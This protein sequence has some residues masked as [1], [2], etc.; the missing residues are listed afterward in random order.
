MCISKEL[1]SSFICENVA[2]EIAQR[3]SFIAMHPL[4]RG[5]PT[6]YKNL[7]TENFQYRKLKFGEHMVRQGDPLKAVCFVIEG[8]VKLTVNPIEH[9]ESFSSLLANSKKK[10]IQDENDGDENKDGDDDDDSFVDP[11]KKI[12]V[13]QRRKLKKTDSFYASELRYRD[14]D[15]CTLGSQAVVGDIESILDLNK[16]I[17]TA[18]CIQETSFYEMDLSSFLRFI[19]KKN[20]E[21]Y[22]KMRKLV[23]EKLLHRNS[24]FE[25]TIPIYRALLTFFD[26][27]KPK[28]NRKQIIKSYNSKKVNQKQPEPKFFEEL[29]KGKSIHG[30]IVRIH[31]SI[32]YVN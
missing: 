15:V 26:K 3:S 28:D 14:V 25:G 23:F 11:F 12:S 24:F 7:L 9:N 4:F 18:V 16:H 22:E 19:V 10:Y 27:P 6:T 13:M 2:A 32:R 31:Q 20:P 1:Y 29:S 21:T 8:Q 30:K 17:S 5:W